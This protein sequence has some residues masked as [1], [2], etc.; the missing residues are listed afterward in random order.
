MNILKI[1]KEIGIPF[2]GFFIFFIIQSIGV[3]REKYLT[4]FLILVAIITFLIRYHH[5][6]W[7]LFVV[8]LSLGIVIEIG[9]RYFGYQ[10]VWK[11][12]SFFGVPY[13]LPIIWGFGF[14]IITRLGI[15]IRGIGML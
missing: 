5:N 10:Q 8:G 7:L 11:D 3:L 2:A 9:L 14:V 15:L 13:W 12:A 1:L 6:E 4:V